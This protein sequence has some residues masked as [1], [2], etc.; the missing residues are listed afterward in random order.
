MLNNSTE[1]GCDKANLTHKPFRV[2]YII[3]V[4]AREQ[5][6]ASLVKIELER[7]GCIVYLA[8]RYV[9]S[10]AYNRFRPDVIIL[11][12]IHKIPELKELAKRCHV[13]LLSAESFSGSPE[14]TIFSY[15]GFE[16]E[17]KCVDIRFCWGDFDKDTLIEAGLF[18]NDRMVVTGHPMTESWYVPQP[19]RKNFPSLIV[20]ISSTSKVLANAF[21]DR[22]MISLIDGLENNSDA[23]GRSNFFDEPNHAECWIGFEAAFVRLMINISDQFPDFQ[24]RIRPHPNESIADY[25]ALELGRSNVRV[26]RDEDITAW[27]DSIDVLLSFISTSQIDASVRGKRVISLKNLFPKWVIEGLPKRLHLPVDDMFPAPY[28]FEELKEILQTPYEE[29]VTVKE[30]INRVF[31]FPSKKRPSEL[32]AEYVCNYLASANVKPSSREVLPTHMGNRLFGFPVSD[33]IFM[34]IQDIKSTIGWSKSR[35]AH[36]YCAHRYGRN[37]N[38]DR[39]AK[40]LIQAFN[41]SRVAS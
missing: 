20:G 26:S 24:I 5:L 7:R 15:Q 29:S 38:I 17:I 11:P 8:S 6:A 13:I 14:T 41:D 2:L 18:E 39:R 19:I 25:S 28:S 31:N 27:I 30:Y 35:V 32:I 36:S 23:N 34:I 3:D 21:G 12:K 4:A 22:N 16:D 37:S 1:I 9:I 10:E 33:I 40:E